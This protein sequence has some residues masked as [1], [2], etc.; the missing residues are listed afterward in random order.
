VI[1]SAYSAVS[2]PFAAAAAKQPQQTSRSGAIRP[3][4]RS[5]RNSP[6]RTTVRSA[7]TI[8]RPC[9]TVFTESPSR[10][11][12][13]VAARRSPTAASATHSGEG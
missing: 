4:A 11:K 1:A 5:L 12:I 6:A 3:A 10:S 13:R 7:E 8:E 9:M 2:I